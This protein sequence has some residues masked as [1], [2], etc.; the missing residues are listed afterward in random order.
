SGRRNSPVPCSTSRTMADSGLS[1]LTAY[2]PGRSTISTRVPPGSVARP[3]REV[4]VVPGK[5]EVFAR[6]PQRRLKTVVLPV[7][8]LPTSATLGNGTG[9]P[10]GRGA[11]A[12]AGTVSACGCGMR[13]HQN[14]V[15]DG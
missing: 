2:S 7:L 8:G 3:V 15:G 12:T 5:F 10:D 1:R 4:V 9:R 13:Q 14:G 6:V 11:V